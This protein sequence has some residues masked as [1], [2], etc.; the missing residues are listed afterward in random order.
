MYR[1]YIKL[2]RKLED[3]FIYQDSEALKLWIHLLFEANHKDREFMFNGKK[4]ICKRGQTIIGLNSLSRKTKVSRS[5]LYRLLKMLENETLIETQKTNR[6]T[7]ITIVCYEKYQ[8]DET[9][10]ETP[11]KLQRNSSETPAKTPKECNN[12][13]N[14]NIREKVKFVPPTPVE[15][16]S[17]IK[18]KGFKG[19][20]GSSFCDFYASKGWMVGKNKMKDWQAA[21]RTWARNN[22]SEVKQRQYK[23]L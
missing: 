21:V 8:S 15:V 11:A 19:F 3:S 10:N 13:N 23:E 4:M 5:K 9:L 22:R 17:Y 16:D 7:L 1:G 18:D 2:W 6:F 12:Y 14:V 20:D